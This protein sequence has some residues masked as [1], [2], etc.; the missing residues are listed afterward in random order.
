MKLIAR[1]S[2]CFFERR[3]KNQYNTSIAEWLWYHNPNGYG[4]SP[5]WD[6]V[7]TYQYA[8]CEWRWTTYKFGYCVCDYLISCGAEKD[9]SLFLTSIIQRNYDLIKY[10]IRNGFEANCNDIKDVLRTQY[11]SS[12]DEYMEFGFT[13]ESADN[14]MYENLM[15]KI[16]S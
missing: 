1:V 2:I 7:L 9:G 13:E 5:I 12:H 10:L 14:M 3:I 6:A 11:L 15:R 16:S 4:H 8:D